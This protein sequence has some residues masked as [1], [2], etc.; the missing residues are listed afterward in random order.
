MRL[1]FGVLSLLIAVAI[2]A[3]VAKKQLQ[4]GTAAGAQAGAAL[5]PTRGG[6][7]S[8]PDSASTGTAS[9]TVPQQSRALQRQVQEE[10][11]RALRQGAERSAD[12]PR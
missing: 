3:A 8:M 12:E 7:A 4:A 2:V 9:P 1:I 5:D 11:G 10:V 6:P